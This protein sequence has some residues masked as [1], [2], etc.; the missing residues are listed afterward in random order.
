MPQQHFFLGTDFLVN[1]KRLNLRCFKG[2]APATVEHE[3]VDDGDEVAG[4]EDSRGARYHHNLRRVAGR[5]ERDAKADGQDCKDY[6]EAAP[7][8][9]APLLAWEPVLHGTPAKAFFYFPNFALA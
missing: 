7:Q 5:G 6:E 8:P 4:Q 3:V 2:R 9:I 1:L